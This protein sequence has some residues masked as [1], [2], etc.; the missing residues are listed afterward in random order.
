MDACAAL[1]AE[2]RMDADAWSGVAG[3][4]LDSS[5]NGFDGVARQ[6]DTT[7][8]VLCRAGDL[9]AASTGQYLDLNHNALDGLTN[10]T[11]MIWLQTTDDSNFILVSG[12]NAGEEKELYWRAAGGD[13]FRPEIKD[14]ADGNIDVPD[15][16]DGAWHHFAWTRDGST[17][18]FYM[19]GVEEECN[20][21]DTGAL[22]IDPTGFI[23]G[24]RQ[25]DINYDF[26]NGWDVRGLVDEF[27]VFDNVMSEA[28]INQV[29]VNNLSGLNW[30]GAS[31]DCAT[32]LP[33]PRGAFFFD[34]PGWNGTPDE[35]LDSSGNDYHGTAFN[36]DTVDGLVCRAADLSAS[37]TADYLS[38]D[39]RVLNGI[40]DFTIS[41]WVNSTN[42][43]NR[44][45][46][47]GARAGGLVQANELIFWFSASTTFRPYFG[48]NSSG[49]SVPF[50]WD[51]T[52][53]HL[54]WVRNGAS[55]CL[56]VDGA[57]AACRNLTTATRFIDPGGLI[58]GQEQDTV[59]GN[60]IASQSVRGLM[61][62]YMFFGQALSGAQVNAI[63][64]NN[65][66]GLSWDGSARTCPAF[67]AA[68][69]E[70][71]HD[72]AGIYCAAERI[73]VR[74]L[75]S[76]G[77]TLTSYASTIVLDTGTGSG[78]WQL[79]VGDGV[80]ADTTPDDGIATY[81]F[82]A[83]DAGQAWFDLSYTGGTPSLDIEVAEQA[84]VSIR[85]NDTE[86]LLTFAPSGFTVTASALSN[87]PPIP[88]ND[89]LGSRTAGTDFNVHLTAFGT[90]EDDPVCG[91][92]ED[93][94]GTRSVEVWQDWVDPGSGPLVTAV[95]STLDSV[96]AGVDEPSANAIDIA[97][98]NGQAFV[99]AKY[100]DAGRLRL[101]FK[102]TSLR[103]S[104]DAFVSPP[105]QLRVISV[106]D[107]SGGANPEAATS[108]DSGFTGAGEAFRVVVDVLDAEGDRTP[109]FGNE[110]AAESPEIASGQLVLP[111]AGRHGSGDDGVLGNGDAFIATLTPGRF[112]NTSVYYD[113]VGIIRLRAE[114]AD[115]DYLGAG[116]VSG[117]LTNNV[118]RFH[119]SYYEMTASL[120][121]L[122][123]GAFVYMGA[124][125]INLQADLLARSA[126]GAT[127]Q[128]YDSGLLG[129][130]G[131]STVVAEAEA[132][133]DGNDLGARINFSAADWQLG[134][135]VL[136]DTD[137]SFSRDVGVD[138]AFETLSLGLKVVDGLD[139][140]AL[141]VLD[142]NA[143]TS[144]ACAPSSCAA[145]EIGVF[146]VYYGRLAVLPAQG[147]E[148]EP[149]DVDLEAQV[150]RNGAFV[151]HLADSCST[152][153]AS[154]VTLSNFR[155]NLDPGETSVVAP[156][157]SETLDQGHTT[158]A[159][160][161]LL[162]PPGTGNEGIVEVQLSVPA[163]LQFDWLGAG[164]TDPGADA[165][166][167]RFRGHDRIIFW[168][169]DPLP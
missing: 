130:G 87:P 63:Y 36:T 33:N 103:G 163:W 56:Y 94:S 13:R 166:F 53:H 141:N 137:A 157:A 100:K 6:A 154:D 24:Q 136:N 134:A 17:N 142:M 23:V 39:N 116:N 93:Y 151:E 123:C 124:P 108:T 91:V 22:D 29:R 131:V 30:D 57:L 15:F 156:L 16:D 58:I 164:D 27:Y 126:Q 5:G 143:A 138:G 44:A 50:V 139:G 77:A 158:A 120:L 21:L 80:L 65:L 51:G 83:T 19:N 152:Y 1:V 20:S 40:G 45:L 97:F 95:T 98:V 68:E 11:L 89:P 47:S 111:G 150:F 122:D 64:Q 60:F 110:F 37:G 146:D 54:A 104:T 12:A 84:N 8:G 59:G 148:T 168:Q 107:G 62:E 4:V 117:P 147:V 74:A 121:S 109:N 160:P 161:L 127:V 18:C 38:I 101:N 32:A 28:E 55:N 96:N 169:Q 34:E 119:P 112:E 7:A 133:D 106:Q 114:I 35:V 10:F 71:N 145:R 61:D 67:G 135:Y 132:A 129:A 144:G 31:R 113:E 165:T 70:I 81:T 69:F 118:G 90:T 167:G 128:N 46:L 82:A 76:G 42:T 66:N 162:S 72:G 43:G 79:A 14:D 75:D 149:L 155:D 140:R 88:I 105:A 3:E 2:Y 41:V 99:S 25:D 9:S 159:Q 102:E 125:H 26:R 86:G 52:W 153:A 49:M 78:T 115:N 85:D 92:I 73:G 48:N